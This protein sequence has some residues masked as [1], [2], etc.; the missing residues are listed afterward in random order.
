MKRQ[1]ES[2]QMLT[3]DDLL[4]MDD[5]DDLD[6]DEPDQ[7]NE[8]QDQ[9]DQIDLDTDPL[10]KEMEEARLAQEAKDREA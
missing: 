10:F 9:P 1:R 7:P 5:L 3:L 8:E 4:D 6:D 2:I